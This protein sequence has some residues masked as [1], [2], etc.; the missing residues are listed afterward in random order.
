MIRLKI[1]RIGI[2]SQ[3]Q[4]ALIILKDESGG[5][6]LPVS[7]GGFE[8]QSIAMAVQGIRPAR[9]LT[10]DLLK[11]MLDSLDVSVA[12]IIIDDL[13]DQVFYA[14]ITLNVDG[15]TIEVDSRPSDAIA[16]AVRANCPIF[17]L[18]RVLVAA[19]VSEEEAG[20]QEEE[21]PLH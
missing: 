20:G 15:R 13:R 12:M 2:D 18:E 7:I 17:A 10:H 4:S 19:G 5:R 6:Y 3:E 11:G 9:P 21:P 14:Q 16:L 8:A 1:D